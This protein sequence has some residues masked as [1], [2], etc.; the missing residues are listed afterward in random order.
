MRK[1]NAIKNAVS[2]GKGKKKMKLITPKRSTK[3]LEKGFLYEVVSE[4]DSFGYYKVREPVNPGYDF[5]GAVHH[6]HKSN[7]KKVQ[8][9]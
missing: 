2:F 3:Q 8:V 7:M 5:N 6:I 4:V 1:Y 9:V